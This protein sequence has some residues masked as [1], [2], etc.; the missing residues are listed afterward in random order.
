VCEAR[1][2]KHEGAEED[3]LQLQRS[4]MLG[5]GAPLG[6]HGPMGCC[7][8][9]ARSPDPAVKCLCGV[10]LDDATRVN[11]GVFSACHPLRAVCCCR[12]SP[13]VG[14]QCENLVSAWP[15][16]TTISSLSVSFCLLWTTAGPCPLYTNA[17]GTP[18]LLDLFLLFLHY[19][20]T[21]FVFL[22]L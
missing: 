1:G 22:Y 20:F 13:Q 16:A 18:R 8:D 14:G 7:K 5:D 11:L 12:V 9:G 21:S 3:R 19:Q 10:F 17:R 15:S 2:S 6:R 4:R